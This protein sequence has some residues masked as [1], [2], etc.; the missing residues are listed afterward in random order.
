MAAALLDYTL[1]YNDARARLVV[2]RR[3]FDSLTPGF[4]QLGGIWLPLP[5]LLQLPLVQS[6]VLYS[7]GFGMVAINV[8]AFAGLAVATLHIVT[9]IT[10]T[11]R[12]GVAAVALV[13]SHPDLLYLQATPMTEMLTL[14]LIAGATALL[15]SPGTERWRTWA[16][17]ALLALAMLTRYEAWLAAGAIVAVTTW[18]ASRQPD[19]A[20]GWGHRVAPLAAMCVAALGCAA[21]WSKAMTGSWF[22]ASG[23]FPQTEVLGRPLSAVSE[24]ARVTVQTAGPGLLILAAAGAHWAITRARCAPAGRMRL[25]A[26]APIPAALLY[27]SLAYAGHPMLNRFAVFLLVPAI[28]LGMAGVLALRNAG[29]VRLRTALVAAVVVWQ[30]GLWVRPPVVREAAMD[31]HQRDAF[32]VVVDALEPVSGDE[33]LLASMWTAA[34]IL[35]DLSTRGMP[36][37]RVVH[38]GNG[39][40]WR[41]AIATPA[42]HVSWVLVTCLPGDGDRVAH[43]LGFSSDFTAAFELAAKTRELELYRLRRTGAIRGSPEFCG[44]PA[45]ARRLDELATPVH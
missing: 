40:H 44:D 33:R 12:A 28:W 31:M 9:R 34:A 1:A 19:G 24:V 36:L 30:A 37:R 21:A 45:P 42:N 16:A 39:E 41:L 22:V 8:A 23:F 43:G 2:A 4:D 14:G 15:L 3:V 26:A 11:P 6:D 35:H 29:W 32:R 27:A 10:G 5:H 7:T 18:G 25:L 38:E 20:R 13:V 17:S